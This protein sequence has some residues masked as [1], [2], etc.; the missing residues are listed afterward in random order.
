MVVLLGKV[1][2]KSRNVWSESWLLC[3]SWL[4]P[5]QTGT[6]PFEKMQTCLSLMYCLCMLWIQV[7]FLGIL[8]ISSLPKI[9]YFIWFQSVHAYLII[10]L[11]SKGD[12]SNIDTWLADFCTVGYYIHLFTRCSFFASV[13]HPSDS[14]VVCKITKIFKMPVISWKMMSLEK[15]EER[16]LK[17][18]WVNKL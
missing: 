8:T 1:A 18:G 7:E 14:D 4:H 12:N 17:S 15:V 5:L 11:Q 16:M 2:D 3:D 9:Q 6:S 10:N 13:C